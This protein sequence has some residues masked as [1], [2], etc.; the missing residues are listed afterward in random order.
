MN[1]KKLLSAV[2]AL[3]MIMSLAACGGQ[4]GGEASKA[5]EGTKAP[6]DPS[7]PADVGDVAN[8]PKVTLVYAEVN[9]LDRKSVV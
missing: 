8:D 5:P 7:E 2:L 4:P 3:L 6:A 9:P 1:L